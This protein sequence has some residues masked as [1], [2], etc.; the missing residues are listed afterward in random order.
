MPRSP[1]TPQVLNPSVVASA[2]PI[3]LDASRRNQTLHEVLEHVALATS[4]REGPEGVA[5]ILRAVHQAER[6]QL[7]DLARQVRLPVPVLAAV[8]RELEHSGLLERKG[9]LHL[10]PK[11]QRFVEEEMGLAT[12]HDPTCEACGGRGLRIDPIFQQVV[13]ALEDCLATFPTVDVTLDQAFPTAESSVRRALYLYRTG[14][15]EGRRVI[16]LGDDDLMSI[17]AALLGRALGRESLTRRLTVVELDPRILE[18]L[19]RV[20]REENLGIEL[21]PHDLREPLPKD[22]RGHFDVFETDPPYTRAG[23]GLFVSRGVEALEP[24]LGRMGFL[25][26]GPRDP[27]EQ[28]AIQRDLGAMGLVITDLVPAFNEYQGASMFGGT[29]QIFRL[30][31]T[32]ESAPAPAVD[33]EP[34]YTGESHPTQR[35]YRCLSCGREITVG[36]G[37]EQ[38]TVEALKAAGC[39]ACQGT[40]FRFLKRL[41]KP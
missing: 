32:L 12:R 3:G 29:S 30:E 34:I 27:D 21:R 1:P 8:R 2:A 23:A 41:M 14:A 26:L 36:Q 22:L 5:R 10:S 7:K 20:N 28:L 35:L 17:S 9:G 19:E 24:G 6:V 11:G 39:P 31:T 15:L 16:V 37:Q 13:Q 33:G 40:R 25:S 18:V 38:A 4:L